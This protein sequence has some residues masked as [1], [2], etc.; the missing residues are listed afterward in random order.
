MASFSIGDLI[1]EGL[2]QYW[3]PHAGWPLPATVTLSRMASLSIGS[4]IQGGLVQYLSWKYLLNLLFQSQVCQWLHWNRKAMSLAKIIAM[5]FAELVSHSY[6][7]GSLV[8][9]PSMIISKF[10][11]WTELWSIPTK[12]SSKSNCLMDFDL[13]CR[14]CHC[15]QNNLYFMTKPN[16]CQFS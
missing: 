11:S 1:L 8:L 5:I 15:L 2:V 10:W 16:T 12:L 13:L 4:L 7:N 3:R 9:T 14:R 6:A